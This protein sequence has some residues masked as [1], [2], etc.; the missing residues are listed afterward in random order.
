M[1]VKKHEDENVGKVVA[2]RGLR[3]GVLGTVAT[4]V[5]AYLPTSIAML[6]VVPQSAEIILLTAVLVA[7]EKYFRVRD[8]A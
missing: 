2:H 3:V 4:F 8:K 6:H 7:V 5:V 1:A